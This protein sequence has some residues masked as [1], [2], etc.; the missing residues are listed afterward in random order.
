MRVLR[1]RLGL[2][3]HR[4]PELPQ[5]EF[6]ERIDDLASGDL[7]GDLDLLRLRLL[8]CSSSDKYRDTV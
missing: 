4:H 6:P 3:R 8:N 1:R 5:G 7:L 2:L